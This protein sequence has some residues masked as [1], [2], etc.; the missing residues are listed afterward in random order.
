M[1]QKNTLNTAYYFDQRYAVAACL[2][3]ALSSVSF[4]ITAACVLDQETFRIPS[5][6]E[7]AF[8]ANHQT[9]AYLRDW[10][11]TTNANAGTMHPQR[12]IDAPTLQR[13]AI[14]WYDTTSPTF[15]WGRYLDDD[16]NDRTRSLTPTSG[17]LQTK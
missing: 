14:A 7:R 2:V 13:E 11:I 9:L 12:F 8:V 16:Q 3:L 6:D 10:S 17:V 4:P 15:G 5:G 1:N